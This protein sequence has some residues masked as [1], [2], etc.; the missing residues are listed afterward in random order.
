MGS[1]FKLGGYTTL[2]RIYISRQIRERVILLN[3]RY[4]EIEQMQI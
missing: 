1:I 4:K 2:D 3:Q